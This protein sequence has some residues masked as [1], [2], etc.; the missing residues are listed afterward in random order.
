M[1]RGH[2]EAT[3]VLVTQAFPEKGRSTMS[4]EEVVRTA[5]EEEGRTDSDVPRLAGCERRRLAKRIAV[6]VSIRSY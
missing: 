5:R 3:Q 4:D 2:S 1:L 6:L